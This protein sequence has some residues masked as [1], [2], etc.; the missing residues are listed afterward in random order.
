MGTGNRDIE[1]LLS[2]TNINMSTIEDQKKQGEKES[3][4]ARW[5]TSNRT[6]ILDRQPRLLV[7]QHTVH[8]PDGPTIDDWTFVITPDFINVAVVEKDVKGEWRW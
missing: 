8:I 5:G 7:E 1:I 3:D 2:N 4:I 6:T